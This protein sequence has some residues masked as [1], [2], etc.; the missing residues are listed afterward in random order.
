[1]IDF[2]LLYVGKSNGMLEIWDA[3]KDDLVKTVDQTD[4]VNA[5]PQSK[6]TRLI[7]HN[8][9]GKVCVINAFSDIHVMDTNLLKK[10]TDSQL[11]YWLHSDDGDEE[12]LDHD[13]EVD[14]T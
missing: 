1:M 12:M 4:L 3:T 7:K 10:D 13:M 2:P 11:G 6:P 8:E 14:S 5:K 9:I